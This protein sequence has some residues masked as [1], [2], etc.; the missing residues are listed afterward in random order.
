VTI[1]GIASSPYTISVNPSATKTYSITAVSDVNCA[2]TSFTGSPTVTVNPKPTSILTGATT[3][4]AGASTNLSVALTGFQPWSITYTDGTTP[5]TI[6]GISASPYLISVNPST[7]K[8]Y[9]ITAVADVNCTGTSFTGTP[10]VTVNPKP[11]S[12]FTGDATICAG[13]STN[14]SVALTGSQPWSITY[15]DGTTPVTISGI[16]ASPYSVSVSPA[17]TKTFTITAVAD[18]H[19]TGTSFSGT[20]IVTVSPKPTT[21]LSGA[22][23]ICIGASTDLS[24]ALTGAQPWS[25]TY[26]DGTT[27]VTIAGISASPYLISVTPSS[28]KTYTVTAVSDANCAGTSFTGTPVVSVNALPTI[29][30]SGGTFCAAGA[31]VTLNANGAGAGTYAWTPNTN[32]SASNIVNPVATPATT[33][34]YTVT[35]TDLNGCSNTA[36][37]TV[38]VNPK[39]TVVANATALSVCTGGNL[40]LT[41]SGANTYVWDNGVTDNV[42]FVPVATK[43]YTVTGTDLNGCVNTASV[44]VV[45]NA[46]LAVTA[47]GGTFCI[48]TAGVTIVATGAGVGG[49]YAWSPT[50][51]LSNP[52]IANPLASPSINTIY[53]VT[54][55]DANGCSNTATASVT[56][57]SKPTVTATSTAAIVCEGQNITLTG[58]GALTYVWDNGVT[59]NVAF[60]ATLTTTYTVIG[61]D[62]NNC[63]NTA[64]KTV[65]VNAK[66]TSTLTGIATICAGGNTNLSVALTGSQPWSI[67]YTDGATP[68]TIAGIAASPYLINVSPASTK[69]YTITAVSDVNC[70]GTSFVGSPL[71]TVNPKPTAT[72]T[73]ATAIC[74]GSSTNLSVAFTGTQPWS[75]TYTDG[76]TPVSI[77]GITASPYVISVNPLVSTTYSVTAVSDVNCIGTSFN[78]TPVVTVNPL[79]TATLSGTTALCIGSSTNL[80]VAFTGT[81]PWSITYTDGTTPVTIAGITASPYLITVS[82]TSSKTYAITALS[83]AHCTGTSFVG[84]PTLTVNPKPTASLSGAATICDGLSTNLSVNLTG[85]QPWSITY[86]D[87]VT[88]V[89]IAGITA[90]PYIINVSPSATKTYSLTAVSD[91]NCTGTSFVG[92]PTVTV[93]SKPTATLSGTAA[94]CIGG[95]TN[96]SVN[97]TGTQPWSITYTDGSNPVTISGITASPYSISVSP[98]ALTTYSIT[99]VNDANCIGSSFVGTPTVTVNPLPSAVISGATTLCVGASTNLSVAFTGTQPWAITYTDGSTPVTI[100]GINTNPYLISVNPSTTKTY[101]I[102]ALSDFNC[103]GTSISG[104]PTVTVN[105]KPTATLSGVATICTGESTNLSLVL[106]GTP[107]WSITYTDGSS[108]VTIAGIT[109]SPYAISVQPSAT[110]TYAVTALSDANCTGTSFVGSPT[111][112]VNPLPTAILSGANTICNGTS[113]NLS[114]ALTGSQPWTITYTDGVTPVTIAGIAASPYLISVNPA[115]TKTYSLTAVHDVNCTGTS[116]IGTPTITVNPT[117]TASI[118]GDAT[119]CAGSST[120]LSVTLTGTQPW[121]ITYTDGTTPV[122]I[123]GISASPYAISVQ[124]LSTKSYSLTA[125]HD[126]NCVGTSMNGNPTITVNP[127]PSATLTGATTICNG[128]SANLSIALTGSQPWS[129]TYTD[130][131]TAQTITGIT[132][133]LYVISVSPLSTKTF[134]LTAVN[135]VNCTG[136]FTGT[137]VVTVNPKPTASISGDA[138]I[139]N[140][141]NTNLTVAFTGTQPWSITYTD[142]TTPV[143]ITGIV[144]SSYSVSVHPSSTKTYS[145]TSLNDAN[146]AGIDFTGTPTVTVNPTPTATLSGDATICNGANTNLTVAFTGSQP[147]SITYTDGSTPVTIA[148]ITASPYTINVN[149]TLSK[150]YSLSALSDANCPGSN[151]TGTAVIT[152]NPNPG[153]NLSGTVTLCEGAQ[154]NLSL[155]L[156]GTQPWTIT[157]TDGTTP[158]LISGITTTPY[159]INVNPS[160]TKTYSVVAVSDANC[161]GTIFTGTPVV[162]VNP[163]PVATI[164]GDATICAG[165]TSNI[166]VTF[167]GTSPWAITYTDGITPVTI[168]GVSAS[169]YAIAVNPLAATTYTLTAVNDVNCT[170]T[171]LNGSATV[172]VNP[173]STATLS[174]DATICAGASTNLSVAFTGVQPWRFTYTDGTTSNT[175]SG[176]TATPYAISV[177]PS[178]TKTFT[179]TAVNDVNCAGTFAGSPV[180]TVNPKPTATFAGTDTICVGTSAALHVTFTGTSPWDITYTDG[181]TPVSITG[182]SANPYSFTVTPVLTSTYSMTSLH[183]ANCVGTNFTGTPTITINAKPT[184]TLSGTTTICKGDLTNLS[185]ALTGAKPWNIT[186]TDGTTPISVTGIMVS[187]Y[188]ISVSPSATKTYSVSA[189][190]D[191]NC[192]GTSLVGSPTVVVR[193]LPTAILAGAT[194]ICNGATTNL[195][196][197]LTGAQPWRITYTDGTTPITIA[198]ITTSLYTITVNPSTTTTYTLTGV[199]DVNCAGTAITGT[200]TIVVNSTPTATLTGTAA[201]CPGS[202]TALSVSF[203]GTSP[204]D[205]T[206]TDGTTPVT[207][208][209]INTSVYTITVNPSTTKTYSLTHVSD[210]NCNGTTLMGTP[211]VTIY[212]NPVVTTTGGAYCES[213]SG[214]TITADGAGLGATY[215]WLPVTALSDPTIANPLAIPLGTTTYTVV[216][217]DANGC[218]DTA[219]AVVVVNLKPIITATGGEFCEGGAGVTLASNG[220][221]ATGSYTWSPAT[222]LSGVSLNNPLATPLATTVYTLT[223]TDSNGCSNVDTALVQVNLKPIISATGGSYCESGAGVTL[224]GSGAGLGGIYLWSPSTNLSDS[225][226]AT[227]IATPISTQTYTLIGTDSKGCSN[228]K[229][230]TVQ[231]NNKPTVTAT[232]T[233][234][235][236]CL[237]D[238]VTLNGFGATS[239]AWDN[240]ISNGKAFKPLTTTTYQVIGTD[241]NN[242]T[243]ATSLTITVNDLPVVTTTGGTMCAGGS[244]VTLGATGAGAGGSY[245]W[246]PVTNLSASN[247]ANPLAKPT[248]TRTYKVTV[249]DV[250]GCMTK[251]SAIVH[252]NAKPVVVA[253][254]PITVCAGSDVL[255][256]GSGAATY[257]WNNGVTDSVVFNPMLTKTYT[258]IGT[259]TNGCFNTASVKITVNST[260]PMVVTGG[261]FCAGGAGVT[262]SATGA[263]ATGTYVWHPAAT[264]SNPMISTPLATPLATTTYT[265]IGTDANGCTDSAQALVTVYDKPLITTTEGAFCAGGT[266]LSLT[267]SGALSYVWSPGLSLVDSTVAAVI[268]NPLVTT[269]YNVT[270]TDL[271]GC[272]STVTATATVIPKSAKPLVTNVGVCLN[273]TPVP[274]L[275]TSVGGTAILWYA[276]AIGG[277]AM[278]VPIV[279]SAVSS[280]D[281]FYV[282][283]TEPTLCESPRTPIYVTV[284]DVLVAP[285]VSH[286]STC[287]NT[288]PAPDMMD[289]VA[290]LN[291][292][293]FTSA[294]SVGDI[295]TPTVNTA[296]VGTNTYFVSQ[297]VSNGCESPRAKIEVTV[298]PLPIAQ[299]VNT[300]LGYCVGENGLTL[301]ADDG[302]SDAQYEWF[303]DGISQAPATIYLDYKNALQGKWYVKVT[304]TATGCSRNADTVTVIENPLPLAA[305]TSTNVSYCANS[306]LGVNLA[307]ADAG[308]PVSYQWF[309]NNIAQSTA[310]ASNK[311]FNNALVGDWQVKVVNT[312]TSCASTSS[313]V[314]VIEKAMPIATITNTASNADYCKGDVG[315]LLSAQAITGAF[316][317]WYKDGASVGAGLTHAKSLAGDWLLRIVVDGCQDT[318]VVFKVSEKPLP[319]AEIT[320]SALSYCEGGTGVILAA[321]DAGIGAT[322]EWFKTGVSQGAA[323]TSLVFNNAKAA[324]WTLITSLNGCTATSIVTTIIENTLPD[325]QITTLGED[326]KYCAG[327]N[328]VTLT[329]KD[330]GVGASYEWYNDGVFIA[331]TTTNTLA[332]ALLGNWTMTVRQGCT[333]TTLLSTPVIEKALPLAVI[334]TS[335]L[336]YCAGATGITLSADVVSGASF[337]WFK[338]NVSLGAASFINTYQNALLGDYTV[339]VKANNCEATSTVTAIKETVLPTATITGSA[340]I[341]DKVGVT[342]PLVI[343]MTGLSP[344][345]VIYQKPDG[346]T[347]T[348]NA[349]LTSPFAVNESLDGDYKVLSISDA[350]C[351]GTVAGVATISYNDA[352]S[353]NL[354]TSTRT[355]VPNTTNFI[356]SFDILNGDA[357]TYVV[358]GATGTLVGHTWTSNPISDAVTASISVTDGNNCNPDTATF[359]KSCLCPADG[360]LSGG[361]TICNDGITKASL[362]VKLQGTAPWDIEYT[363]DNGVAQTITGIATAAYTFSSNTKGVYKLTKV[364]DANCVG[365]TNGNATIL[366]RT[367]PTAT[368]AGNGTICVGKDNANLL[369]N[370]T[371]KAPWDFT[372]VS[373]TGN[374]TITGISTNPYTYT[375]ASVGNYTLAAVK[376]AY[377]AGDIANLSGIGNV[378]AYTSPD[379]S[380]VQ[381]HCDNSNKYYITMDIVGGDANSYQVNGVQGTFVGTTWTSTL[382]NSGAI[383]TFSLT[384]SKNCSPITVANVSKSCACPASAVMSGDKTFCTDGTKANVSIQLKGTSPWNVTYKENNT[385]KTV[386]SVS[387]LLLIPNI[388]KTGNYSLVS[389]SDD[390][391]VGTVSGK[392]TIVANA[393][394]TAI[395]TGGG[396]SCEGATATKVNFN[397]TGAAPYDVIYTDGT[398]PQAIVVTGNT[399]SMATPT[400]GSYAVVAVTD[401]NG[402]VAQSSL[403]TAIVHVLPPS[404]AAIIGDE[405]ICY[406]AQTPITITFDNASN[407]PYRMTYDGGGGYQIISGIKTNPYVLSI[408]PAKNTTFKIIELLDKFNCAN[409]T[410]QD[411]AVVKV[412]KI[413]VVTVINN[414]PFLC[415]GSQTG[416]GFVS[417]LSPTTYHW[418]G[419]APTEIKGMET[420]GER[421][422]IQ[423]TLTNTSIA[424]IEKVV[425]TVTPTFY[426]STNNACVGKSKSTEVMVRV[427]EIPELGL[428]RTSLCVGDSIMIDAGNFP[429]GQYTWA[430]NDSV[431]TNDTLNK[432]LMVVEQGTSKISVSYINACGVLFRDSVWFVSKHHVPVNFDKG[433]TCLG[434]STPLTPTQLSNEEVVDKWVWHVKGISDSLETTKYDPIA[435]YIF[436][437]LGKQ[438]VH[439]I[440]YNDGCKIGDTTKS[441]LI[442]NCAIKTNNTFTPNGDGVNDLWEIPGIEDFPN[443]DIVIFNRWGIIVHHVPGTALVPWDGNND[444]GQA[445]EQGTYYYVITLNKVL[446]SSQIVKGYVTIIRSIND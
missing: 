162:T 31:G 73:G 158:I 254:T 398:T 84:T 115:L 245:A 249:T 68:V 165:K 205:F 334:N 26:T 394:P 108:A 401:A 413:P 325:A 88:P 399:Y 102:T 126:A 155:A 243:N 386:T 21:T 137:P 172:S 19:C 120:N 407:A 362:A 420:P 276:K 434:V 183:D 72:I 79:P 309:N 302:G 182:I 163:K 352:P 389:V 106:T 341:C 439:L 346:A 15:T 179:I 344:W 247:V 23:T 156:T 422:V 291:I 131:T 129:I 83:D 53:T 421:D 426:T 65:T 430:V 252:I 412:A 124:P 286:V 273:S 4:C 322:Y 435:T 397:F 336:E 142:G 105:P 117:P 159:L 290:G 433:D 246:S 57:N 380:H 271:N 104:T 236:L 99:N 64:T 366:Y 208:T 77:A 277:N 315:I 191:A 239:Y 402:C 101:S 47:T 112:T 140:G 390:K 103:T 392:A 69:T 228:T 438:T 288:N 12:T 30:A 272:K 364:R 324:D 408:R 48:G 350:K 371:G 139:C 284:Y 52:N 298:N 169:P 270:G 338:S 199:N 383:A 261:A 230:A 400:E 24:V 307:A 331:T 416:I 242:C 437:T 212:A 9:S 198:G 441:L 107:P 384:D 90:S 419:I 314:K 337:E 317:E 121:S 385:S 18:V 287:V 316:Y 283:Q 151:F 116:L 388:D 143:T 381:L 258:V 335:V 351:A 431:M 327:T 358:T 353:I 361:G 266:G 196:V 93:N 225:T 222:Q 318:S 8:T 241:G 20:P 203:T 289:H 37:A 97:L 218:K 237:G 177:S 415:S 403:G 425:Y 264:L 176:I 255:L 76:T 311:N 91:V 292:K 161:V 305:I 339:K 86:T 378:V 406:G 60:G 295:A 153:A 35:G 38:T 253:G 333:A 300:N 118:A 132:T 174:G 232:A 29:T 74:I 28:T 387:N 260:L 374:K 149:P 100:A 215:A 40:T 41:G 367:A 234:S 217:T 128:A 1:A 166:S 5:V 285:A 49:T 267:A 282:T 213:G 136:T 110:K 372:I 343:T 219:N 192:S 180:V 356:V 187:P 168:T 306:L 268:A 181:V 170:G 36:T 22:A 178:S 184:A 417:T 44:T 323:S 3:I 348:A 45:V 443:A 13:A 188:T 429:T 50:T 96:L 175:I 206:Y 377:C 240:G 231:V 122:T 75:I 274:D 152:V 134:A 221:G 375:A 312:A 275:S 85:T 54:V 235:K 195:S 281:T 370:F 204:W 138:T 357:S 414:T 135:D 229:T 46:S 220:A 157:Y 56:I 250:N 94:I 299:V 194:T 42:S 342:T 269:V 347:I 227:P 256:S 16:S 321:T 164:A 444:S 66:P 171:S 185:V 55:V 244:G 63:S 296:V 404:N 123:A 418:S 405:D 301:M 259:D 201:I 193:N 360:M 319:L 278:A 224:G 190:T 446:N 365:S 6:S 111:V 113:T 332:N 114:V 214:V 71:V 440:A 265:V 363:I 130:G 59:D 369:V 61:T 150:T 70:T 354:L 329:A 189:L 328:G 127:S 320:P 442:K 92:S 27:P 167:T 200:P 210:A 109:T 211:T 280:V 248:A 396:N 202:S 43:T 409:K 376:D 257:V 233:T 445:L 89:T 39:P 7:T 33:T 373:P 424:S 146:C 340:T 303:K 226:I 2:G 395:V 279:N 133:N 359:S 34:V 186:Y 382:I 25:I 67:T 58:A 78:G 427:P 379:T 154:T 17:T 197:A 310:D 147:W 294:T 87:G 330:L 62:A 411:S 81:Q 428:D 368:I 251:D 10:T 432:K 345:K 51:D 393:L 263:G 349:V 238:S 308:T 209:G 145:L 160:T 98:A 293:W 207:I 297:T 14:L 119:I 313:V 82:P 262:L 410:I 355:C 148:G 326:L 144:S 223:G 125:L 391:C 216:G 80:S 304:H 173:A 423:Q 436:P 141:A 95:S 32:L 11:T